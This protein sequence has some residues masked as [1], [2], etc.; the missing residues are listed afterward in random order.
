MET[1]AFRIV[2]SVLTALGLLTALPPLPE[3][4]FE[5]SE[6]ILEVPAR[7]APTTTVPRPP[8]TTEYLDNTIQHCGDVTRLLLKNGWP[9]DQLAYATEIAWRESRCY[10]WVLNELDPNGGSIGLF[11]INQF[12]CLPN[13]YTK[14]GWLQE[15]GVIDSCDDL[16][17]ATLNIRAAL[18]IYNYGVEKHGK[19]WGPWSSAKDAK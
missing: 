13:R 10:P 11:Q 16:Y 5:A 8:T 9:A 3:R 18:A 17:N 12:W 1:V 19:G 14:I 7:P 2:A 6:A 15:Q 4:S